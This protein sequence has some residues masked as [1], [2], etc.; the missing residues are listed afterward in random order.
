MRI[1]E[2]IWINRGTALSTSLVQTMSNL[3]P[4]TITNA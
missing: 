2:E 4:N 1:L 3:G